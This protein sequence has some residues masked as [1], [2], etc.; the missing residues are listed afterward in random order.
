MSRSFFSLGFGLLL[1]LKGRVCTLIGCIVA[2]TVTHVM[3]RVAM[4]PREA[5]RWQET[6]EKEVKVFQVK[7]YHPSY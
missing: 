6:Y 5:K 2:D 1:V 7:T 4:D 3:S